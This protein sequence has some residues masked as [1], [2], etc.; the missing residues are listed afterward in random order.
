MHE[1]IIDIRYLEIIWIHGKIEDLF[2]L[3]SLN[4]TTTFTFNIL[5]YRH[6]MTTFNHLSDRTK[7][8][9]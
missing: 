6:D 4:K 3:I 9:L 1:H 8:I 2:H 7:P 5:S